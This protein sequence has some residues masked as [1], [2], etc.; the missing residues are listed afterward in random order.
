MPFAPSARSQERQ[1]A[2]RGFLADAVSPAEPLFHQQVAQNR[3][4]GSPFQT[5]AVMQRLKAQA[6]ERG[7]WNLFLPD[8]KFG[9]GLP[10]LDYAP[11]AELSGRA[12][13]LAPEAMN[14]AAPDTG[15]ME[16][17]AMFGTPEQQQ[18]WLLPLREGH[19]RPCVSLTEPRAPASD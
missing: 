4:E 15:N 13:E 3:E 6:R 16:V 19:S 17:L 1:D 5:P 11:L 2:V 14:C 12:I 18:R 8:Q 10:V 7:L 9:A